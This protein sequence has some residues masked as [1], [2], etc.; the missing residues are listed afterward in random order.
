MAVRFIIDDYDYV[1]TLFRRSAYCSRVE[2]LTHYSPG[3]LFDLHKRASG[4]HLQSLIDIHKY[5]CIMQL[6]IAF[7]YGLDLP[8][9]R[10]K[11]FY[12]DWVMDIKIIYELVV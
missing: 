1:S 10:K 6:L 3:K 2:Y 9:E 7:L 5:H 12:R 8:S 11:C 4:I